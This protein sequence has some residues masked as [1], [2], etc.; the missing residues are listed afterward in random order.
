MIQRKQS[1]WLLI[2]ALCS[3]T[4]LKISFYTGNINTEK[5][6]VTQFHELNGLEN[7]WLNIVTIAIAVLC[8]T[9]IFLFKNRKLQQRICMIILL[10]ELIVMFVYYKLTKQFIAGSYAIGAILQPLIIVATIMAL[11][12]IRKD[13]RIISESDRLR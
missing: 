10:M 9:T 4:A 3:L 13:E 11:I 8:L 5:Q 1:L 2:S 7:I 12:G 6:S